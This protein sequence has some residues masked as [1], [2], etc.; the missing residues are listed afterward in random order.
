MLEGWDMP[1]L[2][3]LGSTQELLPREH[4]WA[5]PLGDGE[6]GAH[7]LHHPGCCQPDV[8]QGSEAHRPA[9]HR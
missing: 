3:A 5:G 7:S 2:C 6:R 8:M 1:R 9:V 4:A